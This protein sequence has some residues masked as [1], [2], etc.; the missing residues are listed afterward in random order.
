MSAGITV[1]TRGNIRDKETG[2]FLPVPDGV[3]KVRVDGGIL[4]IVEPPEPFD[5]PKGGPEWGEF[6]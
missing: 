3:V 6:A 4:F 2:Q 5:I 1:D